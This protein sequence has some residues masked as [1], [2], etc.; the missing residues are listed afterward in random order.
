M[1]TN[2]IL[3]TVLAA[4][5]TLSTMTIG[6][7][8]SELTAQVVDAPI[9]ISADKTYSNIKFTRAD[10]YTGTMFDV[11]GGKLTLENCVID[12]GAK[13]EFKKILPINL[14]Q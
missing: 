11:K 5:M 7:F 1:K 6:A 4:A 12:A 2:K 8:A 14:W 10:G 3:A 9:E 13:C